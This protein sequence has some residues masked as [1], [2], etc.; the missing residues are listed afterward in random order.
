[1]PA[2]VTEAPLGLDCV[3]LDGTR[4]QCL[5]REDAL[6]VL[7]RQLLRALADLVAPHGGLGTAGTVK[8]RLGGIHQMLR[9]L[10]QLGFAGDAG[11]LTRTVLAEYW[12]GRDNRHEAHDRALLR[13]LDDLE[14][15]LAPD[16]R[17]MVDGRTFHPRLNRNR[18]PLPAYSAREWK[19]LTASAEGAVAQAWD[20]NRQALRDAARGRDLAD[21]LSRENIQFSLLHHGP[22]ALG[23]ATRNGR[24]GR[25]WRAGDFYHGGAPE[26]VSALFPRAWVAFAYRLLFG[27]RTGIVPD[28]LADLG[29]GDVRWSGDATVLLDYVKGRTSQES[30]TLSRSAVRL[31][32]QWLEHSAVARRFAPEELRNQLW[33][34]YW[35]GV[36][37]A[38]RRAGSRPMPGPRGYA[39]TNLSTMPDGPCGS[40]C[41]G[42]ALPSKHRA[43]GH[44]GAA[45]AGPRSTPTTH[46]RW[47]ATTTWPARARRRRT[48][49]R[50]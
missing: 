2:T 1:M 44:R 38:G 39:S 3:F 18:R 13:R 21:G 34:R 19:A 10:D 47:R 43:T 7:A 15:V 29:L 28:G 31:L 11:A 30:L 50:T 36:A 35:S 20:A 17:R 4:A 25:T 12:M 27:I 16:V 24:P 45:A 8:G 37:A 33:L 42:S 48:P 5:L 46:R 40:T 41:T 32:R 6:P 9:G 22:Q 23:R 14:G 49:P 26:A